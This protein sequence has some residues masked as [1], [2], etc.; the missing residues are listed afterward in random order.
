MSS[1]A[2]SFGQAFS[3]SYDAESKRR[4]Q[5][6][7][8]IAQEERLEERMGRTRVYELGQELERENRSATRQLGAEE[9]GRSDR[10][11]RDKEVE[12]L[13][14]RRRL[15]IANEVEAFR[16]KTE[17]R[18]DQELGWK[19]ASRIGF[20]YN[21]DLNRQDWKQQIAD[22]E[23]MKDSN[24]KRVD[25]GLSPIEPTHESVLD[26]G[27]DEYRLFPKAP[28]TRK[29]VAFDIQPPT[30]S[31]LAEIGSAERKREADKLVVASGLIGV[32]AEESQE[33]DAQLRHSDNLYKIVAGS[34]G[35]PAWVIKAMNDPDRVKA[36]AARVEASKYII[37]VPGSV[38]KDGV[39]T[40]DSYAYQEPP[41]PLRPD[42]ANLAPEDIRLFPKAP[43]TEKP[44]GT[45]EL[46]PPNP[47]MGRAGS[48]GE[49][50]GE[51]TGENFPAGQ[52][53][54]S[55]DQKFKV[56]STDSKLSQTQRDVV[57]SVIV[58]AGYKMEDVEGDY[59]DF[60][61]RISMSERNEAKFN[62][63]RIYGAI[64]RLESSKT[65]IFGRKK[66][67]SVSQREKL[68]SDLEKAM[69]ELNPASSA[70]VEKER[71][72]NIIDSAYV[73]RPFMQK[74]RVVK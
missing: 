30:D 10:L 36:H 50:R 14:S 55:V 28:T 48:L 8:E 65:D 21:L 2:K 71:R 11:V 17:E 13:E 12:A 15:A 27:N 33:R 22:F 38:S 37:R 44:G 32:R 66:N 9:R 43:T 58:D 45:A 41:P 63:D 57:E 26:S 16:V 52:P 62:L 60:A 70:Y 46:L 40:Q 54:R 47:A 42:P 23:A 51:G 34:D 74:P 20:G 3:Q 69:A 67:L 39:L 24:R 35:V 31:Q 18:T 72:F 49:R 29:G 1:F 19:A 68:E 25:L 5:K 73:K 4:R 53:E 6:E 64:D 59:S 56:G 7:D 61:R